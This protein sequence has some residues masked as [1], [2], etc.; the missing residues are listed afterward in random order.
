MPA[1][2]IKNRK[3]VQLEQGN[4]RKKIVEIPDAISIAL[5][6]QELGAKR[7]H[8]I[9]LDAA[10]NNSNE[11]EEIV[12]EIIKKLRIPVQV[13]GGIRSIEKAERL[14]KAGA[15]KIILGTAAFKDKS[16]VE[17]ACKKFGKS[18]IMVA[19]DFRNKRI[20]IKGWKEE[21][22]ISVF[23]A[24]NEFESYIEE[25]LFTNINIEGLRKGVDDE[26]LGIISELSEKTKIRII[27]S[28]G[29][30]KIE[31]IKKVKEAGARGVVIGSALYTG[32][33]SFA[34][35]LRLFS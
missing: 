29:I 17:L 32:K 15:A 22:S 33:L 2:D 26:T 9:D 24:V 34:E 31:D 19:F 20:A 35:I 1:L 14:I 3:C 7:L 12:G 13:G 5:R 8:L 16:F 4:E 6:W 27:Y 28:G 10:I 30:T 21:L 23:D 11:N 18:K 25:G